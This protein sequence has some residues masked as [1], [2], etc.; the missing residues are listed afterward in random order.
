MTGMRMRRSF[1]SKPSRRVRRKA[2]LSAIALILASAFASLHTGIT[3][4]AA[5]AEP[6]D[7]ASFYVNTTSQS[8][9]YA[10]GHNQG[11]FDAQHNVSSQVFLDFG[12]QYQD[13]S[14][15]KGPLGS[16]NFSYG[17]I[18]S[19]SEFFA[20]GY[21]QG[22]GTDLTTVLT[23]A[24]GTNNG[25]WVAQ[26]L[27]VSWGQVVQTVSNWVH[28]AGYQRQVIID[29]A[30]DIE[31]WGGAR[32]ADVLQWEAGYAQG[33][34]LPYLN[35]GSADGCPQYTDNNGGC[36]GTSGDWNQYNY[37]YLSWGAPPAQSLPEIYNNAQKNQWVQIDRYGHD[38]QRDT[39]NF[40][41]PLNDYYRDSSSFTP[42]QSWGSM[43][44]GLLY[45]PYLNAYMPYQDT[46][47]AD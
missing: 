24:I 28:T 8:T 43:Q 45:Y 19:L 26:N 33:T 17:Q 37:W 32:A 36:G 27:G 10:L 6:A 23:L 41:G 9:L 3:A 38:Y 47:V 44:G 15:T 4:H 12:G 16:P 5:Q 21:W 13:N 42:A 29:G 30:N 31:T 34:S 14:G 20:W 22:T 7:D 25:N 40:S 1:P 35:F 2:V 11:V 46:V 18:E 39:I